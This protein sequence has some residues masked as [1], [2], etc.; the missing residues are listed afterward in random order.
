MDAGFLA[1]VRMVQAWNGAFGDLDR[2]PD[3]RERQR[4]ID[5]YRETQL[6]GTRDLLAALLDE[7][8]GGL[9][10]V[11]SPEVVGSLSDQDSERVKAL[12]A[13]QEDQGC[14]PDRALA[15]AWALLGL[16]LEV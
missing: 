9:L 8:P 6:E 14:E 2:G 3:L 5:R 4:V 16:P 10:P 1:R 13:K 11:P 12:A 7:L 15:R